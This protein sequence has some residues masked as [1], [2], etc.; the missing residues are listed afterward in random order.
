MFEGE[1]IWLLSLLVLAP[2]FSG[3]EDGRRGSLAEVLEENLE[4]DLKL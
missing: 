2:S 4:S 3:I 1:W